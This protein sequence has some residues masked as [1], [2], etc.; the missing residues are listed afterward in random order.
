MQLIEHHYS[1]YHSHS[2]ISSLPQLLITN[3][4]EQPDLV[5]AP[6]MRTIHIQLHNPAVYLLIRCCNS[7]QSL[8]VYTGAKRGGV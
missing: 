6:D 1:C 7:V 5:D 3:T 2:C 8:V 4:K